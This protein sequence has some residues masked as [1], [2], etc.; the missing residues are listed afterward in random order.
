LFSRTFAAKRKNAAIASPL[1]DGFI[2]Q[3]NRNFHPESAARIPVFETLCGRK[4]GE[5]E[6]ESAGEIPACRD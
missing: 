1:I 6:C 3:G 2:R 5:A 4:R